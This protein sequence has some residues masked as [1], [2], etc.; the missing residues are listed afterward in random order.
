MFVSSTKIQ[1]RG[2]NFIFARGHHRVCFLIYLTNVWNEYIHIV[3]M[4][5]GVYVYTYFLASKRFFLSNLYKCCD[6]SKLFD[7][8]CGIGVLVIIE[9]CV[10]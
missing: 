1:N 3:P 9:V 5:Y 8:L 10:D 7:G 6:I 2:G 4:G